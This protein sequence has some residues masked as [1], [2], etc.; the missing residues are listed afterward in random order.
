LLVCFGALSLSQ[1]AGIQ[2]GA[3]TL[4]YGDSY[5]QKSVN[6]ERY[7][8]RTRQCIEQ[9]WLMCQSQI[10]PPLA[11]NRHCAVCD[12]QLR[13]RELAV[14]R[15]D[16]SL[17]AVMTAKERAKCIARGTSTITQLSY[18][19]RARR[20]K[21]GKPDTGRLESPARLKA[22]PVK[23]D[24]KLKALAIKKNQ[25]HVVDAKSISF[26]G[27]PVF[28][29]V[30]G[31]SDRQFYYLIGLRYDQGGEI[32]ERS[33]WADSLD[34]EQQL[35]NNLLLILKSIDKP[36]IV[37]YGTYERK[38]LLNMRE[39]YSS[40]ASDLAYIDKL[41][42]TSVN[43]IDYIY[44]RIY[45]PTFSNSL[46]DIGRYLG[47]RWSWSHA[48]GAAASLL[49]RTWEFSKDQ[50]LKRE[51]V[52]YN[53]A[54][55]R[56]AMAVA[57]AISRVCDAGECG[58][59]VD[60][61]S[62]A[63]GFQRPYCKLVSA[64]PEF[65]K[66]NS[67]AYWDYQRAKVYVRTDQS[68]Q[69]T[70][71]NVKLKRKVVPV[72]KKLPVGVAPTS[73]SN[74]NSKDIKKISD[75]SYVT[76]DL[77][78][79]RNGI[80]RWAVRYF[81]SKYQC[82]GCR[83]KFTTFAGRMVYGNNLRSFLVYLMIELRLSNQKAAEHASLLFNLPVDADTA[84]YIK[85]AMAEKYTRTYRNILAEI[86]RGRLIHADE[87]KGVVKGGEHYM[88]VFA[89]LTT[90]AYVYAESRESAIL[91]EVL[92]GFSGVL[93]SDFYTAYDSV[94]CAQQKCLIHLMRDIN[95]DLVKNPF[96][97]ELREI[98]SGFGGLL[99]D[100]VGTID[101][102]GL[103]ARHLGKHR[104]PAAR[105]IE[106]V[107]SMDCSSEAALGLKKRI[108]KNK[109]KLFTFLNFDGVP[110]NNNNAEHAVRAFTRL[111]NGIMHSTPKGHREYAVLLTIQQTLHCRGK[112][113]LDFMRSGRLEIEG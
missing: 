14:E 80:K 44:G 7:T 60:V 57:G 11:L 111:R 24:H 93:V 92:N 75:G 86:T 59:A 101:I 68:V 34:E 54:D 65:D 33:F 50:A 51:L 70:I 73:C 94:P 23:N 41:I 74:C 112:N 37:S 29:D 49:R 19:Y 35:W 107:L 42:E 85:T 45:F 46:K 6:L 79:M 100:I 47:C 106:H 104:K 58:N 21:R 2:A 17:L 82:Q 26:A 3:G 8:A 63:I 81:F 20:R 95:E 56:A 18:G 12:F 10:P 28:L 110:W 15:D 55:C 27:I 1:V 113:F 31:A 25:I 4:I 109:D 76:Y 40:S 62:L 13:C 69:K 43:L 103:K 36:Q 9:I 61:D 5:H 87:T 38:F 64:L 77:K 52:E 22:A 72:E 71:R 105:F 78:F 88:W 89:N 48:S 84:F 53:I 97:G 32:I 39:Q 16:L 30:E 98:A 96:D 67:A 90:A 66:I 102:Y 108:E 83:S 91:T 99:R